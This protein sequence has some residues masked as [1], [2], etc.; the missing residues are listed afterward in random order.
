M[1]RIATKLARLVHTIKIALNPRGINSKNS[2]SQVL[3]LSACVV[4]P[5]P[6]LTSTNMEATEQIWPSQ[7][8][9]EN[10]VGDTYIMQN[11]TADSMVPKSESKSGSTV[12]NFRNTARQTAQTCQESWVSPQN[13]RLRIFLALSSCFKGYLNTRNKSAK[14]SWQSYTPILS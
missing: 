1:Y 6:Q 13:S 9:C 10:K 5:S 4:T 8:C 12:S 2:E 11:F 3:H 7:F 14:V